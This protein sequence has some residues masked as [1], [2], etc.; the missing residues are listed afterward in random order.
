MLLEN[1]DK[2]SFLP[3]ED[4]LSNQ[5]WLLLM[6]HSYSAY[7]IHRTSHQGLNSFRKVKIQISELLKTKKYLKIL[8]SELS[9]GHHFAKSIKPFSWA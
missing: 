9:E 3:I 7:C 2:S 5:L 4:Y 8:F 6:F 1:E